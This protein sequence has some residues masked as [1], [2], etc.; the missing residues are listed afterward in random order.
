MAAE[1]TRVVYTCG[2]YVAR[3]AAYIRVRVTFQREV[4]TSGPGEFDSTLR[5]SVDYVT[6][7]VPEAEG[8]EVSELVR[9]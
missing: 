4:G 1:M 5:M 6:N 2:K 8:S 9:L 3:L 7:Y